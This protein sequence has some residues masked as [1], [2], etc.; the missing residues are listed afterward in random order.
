M[1]RRQKN[2][3][4]NLIFVLI[5]TVGFVVF[6]T[7]IRSSINSSEAA[8]SMELLGKEALKYRRQYGS[9]P[10]EPYIE[11]VRK[12]L[13][14]VRLGDIHYRAQWIDFGADANNTVLAYTTK[15][16]KRFFKKYH[17]VLWLDGRVERCAE[18]EFEK[19]CHEQQ[20]EFELEWLRKHILQ[21][22]RMPAEPDLF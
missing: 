9:L 8:K 19:I 21:K 11:T 12:N 10:S 13:G 22:P 4:T 20:Q 7:N 14:I 18:V 15:P 6:M 17:I 2:L 3:L 16:F 1:N 5:I